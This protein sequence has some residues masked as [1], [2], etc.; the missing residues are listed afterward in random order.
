MSQ[1]IRAAGGSKPTH[2]TTIGS[3]I[4]S[5]RFQDAGTVWPSK[6]KID[7]NYKIKVRF[8]LYWVGRSLQLNLNQE[9]TEQAKRERQVISTNELRPKLK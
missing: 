3:Q 8:S 9:V 1:T 2:F 4:T 7:I 6:F 5:L